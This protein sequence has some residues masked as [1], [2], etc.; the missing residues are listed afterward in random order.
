MTALL[1]AGYLASVSI[2]FPRWLRVAQREHYAA[3]RVTTFAARWWRSSPGNL[4]LVVAVVAGSVVAV[5]FDGLLALGFAVIAFAGLGVAP[6]GL[7]LRGRTSPLRWT[8]RLRVLTVVAATVTG[9]LAAAVVLAGA[10][11]WLAA[12]AL[13]HPIIIDG[14]LAVTSPLE[15]VLTERYVRSARQV[16]GR[17]NPLVVGITGSYGKTSV[18]NYT[19]HLLR[20]SR[21][22]V[23]SRASFNNRLGLAR[24]VNEDLGPGT[25]V[26]L[27]EM[28]TYGPGEIRDLCGWL[29]P[30]VGVITGIGP[31]HLERMKSIENIVAA[32]AE[33]VAN[34]E[35]AV[36]NVDVPELRAVAE[37]RQRRRR[38]V[39][40]CS[41]RDGNAD[42]VV[43]WHGSDLEV[44]VGN[45]SE[46][47]TAPV[48]EVAPINLALAL[49]V[50]RALDALP[51][52]FADGVDTL[53]AVPN[54][55]T[56]LRRNDGPI[57]IDDT[58]NANPAGVRRAL[59]TL[60]AV[61]NEPGQRRVL[62]TPGMIELGTRQSAENRA[63]A[64]QA[65]RIATD[66]V[67]VGR[68]NRRDLLSGLAGAQT[69]NT[70]VVANRE[71]A[72]AWHR[73]HLQPGDVVLFENDL[74]DHYP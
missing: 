24:S 59:A 27:A 44:R 33:I 1:I 8:R 74:P 64:E 60:D 31:V 57:I 40:R 65:S 7:S 54:R 52:S 11:G 49:G 50:T 43:R 16:L 39:V 34:V 62:V 23:A 15:R 29:R 36:L 20:R 35:V 56:V 17:V 67:V 42:V 73:T 10:P 72:V 58:Y 68:T 22:T 14:T 69:T 13:V 30:T 70:V 53:P 26:F 41:E 9:G 71:Q 28:G 63:F 4:G 25:E 48:V 12:L 51:S 32:K 19:A 46:I 47:V 61:A 45:R 37:D 66:V 38:R 5:L 6:L 55:I 21:K 18:K 2:S 3:G